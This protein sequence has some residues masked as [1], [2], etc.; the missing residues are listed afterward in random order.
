MRI[1]KNNVPPKGKPGSGKG[2]DMKKPK[3]APQGRF[4]VVSG[5][6]PIKKPAA[7]GE[8]RS[9]PSYPITDDEKSALDRDIVK[10]SR[11][12]GSRTLRAIKRQVKD[13]LE[14]PKQ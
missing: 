9:G 1:P 6:D 12:E 4:D 13:N 2:A 7:T 10:K 3:K 5:V 8:E 11:K 14:N